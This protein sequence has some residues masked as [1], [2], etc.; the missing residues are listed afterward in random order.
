MKDYMGLNN[1]KKTVSGNPLP[2][3]SS[4]KAVFQKENKMMRFITFREKK[5]WKGI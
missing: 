4:G 3:L 2:T 5:N 1:T